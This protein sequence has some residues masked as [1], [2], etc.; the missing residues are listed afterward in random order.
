[1]S[2]LADLLSTLFDRRYVFMGKR[3]ERPLTEL[4]NALMSSQGDVSGAAI[5]HE[6]LDGYATTDT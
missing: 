4:C 1:M 2:L 6:I 5:A 3:D